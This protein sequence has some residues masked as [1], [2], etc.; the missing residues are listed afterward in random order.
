MKLELLAIFLVFALLV[1]GCSQSDQAPAT[2]SPASAPPA[3]SQ[4]SATQPAPQEPASPQQP[5]TPPETTSPATAPEAMEPAAEPAAPAATPPEVP[6]Q[7]NMPGSGLPPIS[8]QIPAAAVTEVAIKDFA[9][10]PAEATIPRGT[11]IRWTNNDAQPHQ[12]QGTGFESEPLETGGSYV[13]TFEEAGTYDYIC[14]I[15]PSMA[16][17]IIVE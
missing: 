13:F 4:P 12:I 3:D 2:T 15:H 8:Q 11:T 17:R 1:A 14:S 9:F 6:Q 5:S 7:P 16:G 10:S